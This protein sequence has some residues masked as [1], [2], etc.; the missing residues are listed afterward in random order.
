[1]KLAQY[2][3]ETGTNAAAFG[4]QVGV[5]NRQTMFKYIAGDR[6]P[7]PETARLIVEATDGKVT[8]LDLRPDL[9]P[10]LSK[11]SSLNAAA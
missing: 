1:M 2:I 9:A 7:P 4:R 8:L 10:V 5:K 11:P 3:R 6:L